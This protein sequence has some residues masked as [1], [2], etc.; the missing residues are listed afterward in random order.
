[1]ELEQQ[2]LRLQM[3]PHFIFNTLNS[4]QGLISL[5]DT[6]EARRQL[7]DFSQLMRS[8]LENSREE[9]IPLAEELEACRR[10]ANL[11]KTARGL[12]FEI[13]I[14]DQTKGQSWV[15][16]LILQP[17]VEN[18]IVHG[19][20]ELKRQGQITIC[21][22]EENKHLIIDVIDNG[23][24]RNSDGNHSDHR[25]LGIKVTR[26]RIENGSFAG[27]LVFEDLFNAENQ[28]CGTAIHIKFSIESME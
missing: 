13:I 6:K 27:N 28:A 21:C 1:L 8:T 22:K 14:D 25:S 2:A 20:K 7:S 19:F 5:K 16:P 12:D 3:N 9:L 23:V 15:P 11:E 10:Y 18:A 4:I 26:E 24:G 17:F